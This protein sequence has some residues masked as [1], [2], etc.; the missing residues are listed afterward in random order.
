LPIQKIFAHLSCADLQKS[1]PASK[2]AVRERTDLERR[3]LA[4]LKDRM[5]APET[6]AE[7]MRAYSG[8]RADST[9]NAAPAAKAT[10]PSWRRSN[11]PLSN[12][13]FD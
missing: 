5:M 13:E 2:P 8:E 1:M 3:V 10:T 9:A 12:A 11:V 7:T 4:G 6:A